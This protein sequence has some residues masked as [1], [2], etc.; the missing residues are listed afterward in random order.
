MEN[1][2]IVLLLLAIIGLSNVLNHLV[3]FI[4]VPLIQ[5]ALGVMI[6]IIPFGIH[7]PMETELFL[8]L[9]IAPLLFN[10]GRNASRIT[11]WK[12]KTPIL[13]MALGLVFI[14]V[15]II[16]Y[17]IHWLIPTIPL[18]ASFALAA[19]L[20][21]TDAV[22]VSAMS[23]RVKM[24]KI[25]LHI[26]E[27]EGLMN[28]ASG[29]VAFNFAIVAMVTGVFSLLNAS[30]SFVIIA[31]GGFIGGAFLAY[32]IIRIRVLLRHFGM[33]DVTVHMLIQ[34]LTPFVIF[35]ITEHFHLSGILA[36]V[37]AGIVHAIEKDHEKSPKVDLQ[38]VSKS[39]WTVILYVLNGL[40]FVLLG[41]QIPSVASTIIKDPLFNNFV[42]I[43]YIV[44]ITAALLIL[45]FVWIFL[46]GSISLRIQKRRI[47]KLS[48]R[49][50]ALTTLG[51]VRGAVTL[52][53]AFSIPYVL[54]DGSPFPERSLILFI[55]A[56]V[57]LLTL[58]IASIFL[59]L[60][61]KSDGDKNEVEKEKIKNWALIQMSIAAIRA[62][63]NSMN[64]ENR[65]SALSI[66][67]SYNKKIHQLRSGNEEESSNAVK[68]SEVQIRLKALE[69]ESQYIAKLGKN[70]EIDRETAYLCQEHIHRRE[71]AIT[72]QMKY[73]AL[74]IGNTIKRIL[75]RILH[76][77][78]P[79]KETMLQKR[80]KQYQKMVELKI[81][82]AKAAINQLVKEMSSENKDILY[83][84]IGE[85][86]EWILILK[87]IKDKHTSKIN[88]R[89]ERELKNKAFQAERDALQEMFEKG[90]LP[91]ELV[92]KLR[93]QI[94]IR[95][96]YWIEGKG[97]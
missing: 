74:V 6:A 75:I 84:V 67:T 42:A 57:I 66:I 68:N 73:R 10:D 93:Q 70:K 90:K 49:Q 25:I 69:A 50:I 20:S 52:A 87:K 7:I 8:V 63:K 35:L 61:A 60:I 55:A 13:L 72:N 81:E 79:Q 22:A 78:S 33:E 2:F 14:T 23:S 29:L 4:P 62:I 39:T 16:G 37:A 32:I 28:D 21:P 46:S 96:V 9:F 97:L 18:P 83:L 40:V 91:V 89:Y 27:G 15:F 77:L 82:M 95:E 34:I 43:K 47:A 58:I 41:I 64:D 56:G 88:E 36:V 86:N 1:F 85:Y 24:P 80:R 17:F 71:M 76:V 5:I 19:L 12:L 94:N 53:G 26:L 51:G 92:R 30:I 45:R 44:L 3:P 54:E 31:I 48:F 59:P 38:I 65:A 11:L